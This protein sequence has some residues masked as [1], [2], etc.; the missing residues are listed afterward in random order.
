MGLFMG[1]EAVR[2]DGG[3]TLF[4]I[5][6]Y[7]SSADGRES[8]IAVK[9]SKANREIGTLAPCADGR[10]ADRIAAPTASG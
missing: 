4:G 2:G 3:C 1:S 8:T 6:N 10:A 5:G 7:W 9:I